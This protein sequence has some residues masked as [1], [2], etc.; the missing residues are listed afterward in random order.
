RLE[1]FIQAR[2]FPLGIFGAL[3]PAITVLLVR[4]RAPAPV[5]ALVCNL[6]TLGPVL[7]HLA[8]AVLQRRGHLERLLLGCA[9]GEPSLLHDRAERGIP[10]RE[11]VPYL[12][13]NRDRIRS[14]KREVG[15]LHPAD[16]IGSPLDVAPVEDVMPLPPREKALDLHGRAVGTSGPFET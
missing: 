13:E 5:L 9:D 4:M 7:L 6:L 16:D 12:I 8:R 15:F 2:Q 14:Q 11:L 3:A 1:S 10:P